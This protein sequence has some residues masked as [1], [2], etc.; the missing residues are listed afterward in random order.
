MS[1]LALPAAAALAATPPARRQGA[2]R[3]LAARLRRAETAP[4]AAGPT[5][6]ADLNLK[7]PR[8]E[9]PPCPQSSPA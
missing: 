6:D 5:A 8:K 9:T 1:T 7:R 4:A 2:Q 3:L